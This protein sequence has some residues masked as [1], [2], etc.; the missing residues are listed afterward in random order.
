MAPD[1]K[2]TFPLL[3]VRETDTTVRVKD[4]QTIIIAGLIQD[5]KEEHNIGVPVL[6][7]LPGVGALFRYKTSTKTKAE[8]VIMITPHLQIGSKMEDL[9]KK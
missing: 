8:L 6:G 3:A 2:S 7:T 5:R 4:G 1:G 9:T